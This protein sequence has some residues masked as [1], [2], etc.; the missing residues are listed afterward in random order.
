[1]SP[2]VKY[3][4]LEKQ[5]HQYRP[6]RRGRAPF[7]PIFQTQQLGV[8]AREEEKQL[9][10]VRDQLA[11]QQSQERFAVG[12]VVQ[13]FVGLAL[14]HSGLAVS[15]IQELALST[16]DDPHGNDVDKALL[17]GVIG[18]GVTSVTGVG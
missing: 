13:L 17:R 8:T 15:L 3:E 5:P 16:L 1:M 14:P 18:Q 4:E 6:L 11:V 7:V 2:E 12:L 9:S 10:S